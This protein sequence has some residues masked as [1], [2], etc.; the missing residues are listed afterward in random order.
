MRWK[1]VATDELRNYEAMRASL[2]SLPNLIERQETAITRIR[3]SD[4]GK[5]VG[6][7]GGSNDS[8]LSAIV[9]RD[10]LK[11]RL[12]EA[13]KT[14]AAIE[15]SLKSLTDDDALVLDMLF[16]HPRKNAIDAVCEALCIE[17]TTAYERRN[18]ALE[19]FI[20]ALYGC[21]IG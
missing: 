21:T 2:E 19:R 14:V 8:L 18:K 9:Y 4:P 12:Q 3:T 15:R 13:K 1:T 20:C 10:E 7:G 5:V 11:L 16:I 6:P 17:K